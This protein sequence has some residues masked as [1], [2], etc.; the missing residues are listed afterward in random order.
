MIDGPPGISLGKVG[1]PGAPR[2]GVISELTFKF[3]SFVLTDRLTSDRKQLWLSGDPI[4]PTPEIGR[5]PL[6][7]CYS[8]SSRL[9]LK[10]FA[11][12]ASSF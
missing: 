8:V 12:F 7:L 3:N 6:P 11:I 9:S 4:G 10:L 1:Y 2:Y 5:I